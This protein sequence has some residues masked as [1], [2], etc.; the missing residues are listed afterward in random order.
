[1]RRVIF[2]ISHCGHR[3]P[4]QGRLLDLRHTRAR[5]IWAHSHT[6]HQPV[7]EPVGQLFGA[8]AVHDTPSMHQR[9]TQVDQDFQRTT[10]LPISF[11]EVSL[12]ETQLEHIDGVARSRSATN[13]RALFGTHHAE[14]ARPSAAIGAF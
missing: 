12:S 8:D 2:G 14:P 5:L 1:M 6:G 4:N 3:T 13:A 7:A 11:T 9:G 10:W